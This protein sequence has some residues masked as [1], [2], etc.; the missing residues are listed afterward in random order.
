MKQWYKILRD[1]LKNVHIKEK[2]AG[3]YFC[4]LTASASIHKYAKCKVSE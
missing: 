4:G 1:K 2:Q 3:L